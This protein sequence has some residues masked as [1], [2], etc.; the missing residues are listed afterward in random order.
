MEITDTQPRVLTHIEIDVGFQDLVPKI[1]TSGTRPEI[2]ETAKRTLDIVK[3]M[4]QPAAVYRWVEFQQT[5]TDTMGRI[6]PNSDSHVDIDFGHSIRF[7]SHATH[8][9]VSVYT[10]GSQL[11]Q[12]SK[13][14]VGEGELLEAYF[15]DIIGLIVLD[16][17]GDRIRQI[18]EQKAAESGWGVG[19]FLSP[20][21]VHGWELENQTELCAILPLEKIDVSIQDNA[22][23]SPFTTVSCLIG[24]GEGYDELKVGSACQVCSKNHDCQMKLH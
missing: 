1:K 3:N 23:L 10:A 5:Q 8:A 17:A 4:W 13:K 6:I 14:A 9:L 18:A 20:G 24:L 11:E 12:A 15:L 16:K 2:A 22:V 21:S 19:P 7:L